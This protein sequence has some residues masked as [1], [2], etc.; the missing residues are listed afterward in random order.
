MYLELFLDITEYLK[1]YKLVH[2][3]QLVSPYEWV[4][5][6]TVPR[7]TMLKITVE[8]QENQRFRYTLQLHFRP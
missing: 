4:N 8:R 7:V 6:E 1:V 3:L 5:P 2:F